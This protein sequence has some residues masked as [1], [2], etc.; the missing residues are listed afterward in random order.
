MGIE[1]SRTIEIGRL[2]C[3]EEEDDDDGDDG[4]DIVCSEVCFS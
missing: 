1:R 4:D 2:L 3:E